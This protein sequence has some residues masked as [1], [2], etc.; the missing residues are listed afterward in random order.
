[1][2]RHIN[3]DNMRRLTPEAAAAHVDSVICHGM[4]RYIPQEVR[5]IGVSSIPWFDEECYSAMLAT[6][7]GGPPERAAYQLSMQ[8][9]QVAYKHKIRRRIRGT[10]L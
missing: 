2:H 8:C 3:R 5:P 10:S 1:M 6:Q 9:K 4:Q 7:S